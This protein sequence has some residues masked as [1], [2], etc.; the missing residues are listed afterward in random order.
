MCIHNYCYLL[1][2]VI[3]YP[4]IDE[5]SEGMDNCDENANCTNTM[6]GYN[7]ACNTGYEGDGFAG[8]CNSEL[9]TPYN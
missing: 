5:C 3:F 8:S 2:V 1:S 4:D 9:L 7:C 6:G